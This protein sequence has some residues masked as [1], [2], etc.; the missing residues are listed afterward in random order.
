MCLSLLNPTAIAGWNFRRCLYLFFFRLI[1]HKPTQS[2]T[3]LDICTNVPRWVLETRLFGGKTVEGQG[4]ESPAWIAAL[5]YDTI[6][7]IYVRSK[8]D[9]MASLV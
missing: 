8:A 6:R 1:S 3:K 4:H 7:Y 2:I 9:E 5:L